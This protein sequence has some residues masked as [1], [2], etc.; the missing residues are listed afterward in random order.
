[1]PSEMCPVCKG[2]G[3]SVSQRHYNKVSGGTPTEQ[4]CWMCGGKGTVEKEPTQHIFLHKYYSVGDT[5][6]IKEG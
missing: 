3:R 4:E 6:A 2:S 5:D 1:M